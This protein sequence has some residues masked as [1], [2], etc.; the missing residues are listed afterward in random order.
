[1]D[2][3]LTKQLKECIQFLNSINELDGD[4]YYDDI[5]T[6][7]MII[8]NNKKYQSIIYYARFCRMELIN[9]YGVIETEC[10][11][12]LNDNGFHIENTG[13]QIFIRTEKGLIIL[14]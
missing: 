2:K 7:K 14:K 8:A 6:N 10:Q 5:L 1:M 13:E 12:L 4:F 9:F 3:A 11:A